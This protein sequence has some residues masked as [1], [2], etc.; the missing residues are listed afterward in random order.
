M[1]TR[2]S[3]GA[4]PKPLSALELATSGNRDD[5]RNP[6]RQPRY[7]RREREHEVTCSMNGDDAGPPVAAARIRAML[8]GAQDDIWMACVLWPNLKMVQ[9]TGICRGPPLST[10][11]SVQ[12]A[13]VFDFS[14]SFAW[15]A[16]FAARPQHC[17]SLP[18]SWA[19]AVVLGAA[20]P[21]PHLNRM[22]TLVVNGI[23][24]PDRSRTSGRHV[25][26]IETSSDS[27]AWRRCSTLCLDFYSHFAPFACSHS[28]L[29]RSKVIAPVEGNGKAAGQAPTRSDTLADAPLLMMT[30]HT[31]RSWCS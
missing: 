17:G 14:W 16:T 30:V 13:S 28:L 8:G 12:R 24:N 5:I 31:Q 2:P 27:N 25:A 9:H 29:A 1:S 6:G 3:G 4:A 20:F 22:R 18:Q 11:V 26:D 15:R 19:C 7:A 21:S 10:L 23:G